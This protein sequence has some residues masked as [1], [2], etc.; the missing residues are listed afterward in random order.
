MYIEAVASGM[1]GAGAN[2]MINPPDP[3]RQYPLSLAEVAVFDRGV[4]DLL[5]D[6]T[7]IYDMAK[8]WSRWEEGG[9]RE[10]GGTCRR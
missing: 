7:V 1:F 3:S 2:G 5:M 6:L 10:G 8:V 9:G 4:Y